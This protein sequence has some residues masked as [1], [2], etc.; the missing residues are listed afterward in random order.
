MFLHGSLHLQEAPFERITISVHLPVDVDRPGAAPT[1]SEM[2]S[3]GP[4]DG[5]VLG[6]SSVAVSELA[7][8][9]YRVVCSISTRRIHRF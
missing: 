7:V 6:Y 2:D 3:I 4:N 1:L 9:F 5:I 8:I